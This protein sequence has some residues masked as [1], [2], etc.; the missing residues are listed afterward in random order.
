MIILNEKGLRKIWAKMLIKTKHR[1][2]CFHFSHRNALEDLVDS[3]R[4]VWVSTLQDKV[5]VIKKCQSI[6]NI[7][8]D[9]SIDKVI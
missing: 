3:G 7:P 6:P 8:N 4:F 5:Y 2:G 9:F 1:V